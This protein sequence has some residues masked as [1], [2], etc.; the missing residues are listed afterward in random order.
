MRGKIRKR[1]LNSGKMS[2]FIDYYPPVWNVQKKTYTRWEF[3]KL[4]ISPDPK[5][6]FEKKQNDLNV[7][8]AEKI[9]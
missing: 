3:L 2:L 9:F 4:H 8:I 6:A 7:E 1:L 5:T